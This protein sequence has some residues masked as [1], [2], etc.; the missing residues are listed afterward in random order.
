[1]LFAVLTL[2]VTTDM[3]IDHILFVR[4]LFRCTLKYK[5]FKNLYDLE[6]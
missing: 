2:D 3:V 5:I 4:A 1:M 6:I